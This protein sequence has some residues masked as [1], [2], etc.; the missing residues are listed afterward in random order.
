M[1]LT[2]QDMNINNVLI[3]AKAGRNDNPRF[4]NNLFLGTSGQNKS[5]DKIL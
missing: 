3:G 4:A 1:V 2:S 5:C